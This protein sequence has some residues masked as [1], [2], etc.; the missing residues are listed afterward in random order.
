MERIGD[1][2][3]DAGEHDVG[4]D[5]I[6]DV[7]ARQW[8]KRD[9]SSTTRLHCAVGRSDQVIPSRHHILAAHET[10]EDRFLAAGAGGNGAGRLSRPGHRLRGQDHHHAVAVLVLQH[11]LQRLRVTLR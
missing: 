8:S 7:D 4:L 3:R 5:G 2:I 11:D 9:T 6:G 1:V 10:G